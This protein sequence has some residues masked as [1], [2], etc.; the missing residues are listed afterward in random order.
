MRTKIAPD[1]G[2]RIAPKAPS[3]RILQFG[4]HYLSKYVLHD[5]R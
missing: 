1:A 4:A 5:N 2:S 3:G